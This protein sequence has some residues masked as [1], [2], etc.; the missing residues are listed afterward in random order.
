MNENAWDIQKAFHDYVEIGQ[1][2]LLKGTMTWD[3]YA[4]GCI[5]FELKLQSLGVKV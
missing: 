4:F 5:G 2:K 1:D 3:E